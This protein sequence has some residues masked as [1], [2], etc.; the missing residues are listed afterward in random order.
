MSRKWFL[1][2]PGLAFASTAQAEWALN[3]RTGVTDLSAETYGLHM[4]V[5]WWCVGI[6]V[7]VFGAM[8]YSLIRHRKSVGAK[9]AKF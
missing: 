1:S 6:G 8:I 5:F 9:P 3:M 2:L 4:M 7:V